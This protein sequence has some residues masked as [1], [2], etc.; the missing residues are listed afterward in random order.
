MTGPDE[1]LLCRQRRHTQSLVWQFPSKMPPKQTLV[2][3]GVWLVF[4]WCHLVLTLV[5]PS[6]VYTK[7][8]DLP[9]EVQQAAT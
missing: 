8:L 7:I 1:F 6:G 3:V 9:L 4:E 5:F 2:L